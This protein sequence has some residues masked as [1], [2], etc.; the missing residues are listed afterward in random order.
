MKFNIDEYYNYHINLNKNKIIKCENCNCNI[1]N[2]S[3]TNIAHILPKSNFK[4][5]SND[6]HNYMYLCLNCHG[7]YDYS[8]K[9]AATMPV[10]NIAITRFKLFSNKLTPKEQYKI[11]DVF[12][13]YYLFE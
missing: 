7:T 2:I 1:Y 12:K 8:F 11:P 13:K 3:R 9:K 10:I 6:V 4:S 5:V